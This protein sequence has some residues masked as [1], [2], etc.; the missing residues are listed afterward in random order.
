LS[1][2]EKERDEEVTDVEKGSLGDIQ[3]PRSEKV[4]ERRE[5]AARDL[6]YV[7]AIIFSVIVL[8]PFAYFIFKGQIPK[9]LLG[10]LQ[11]VL[12]PVSTLLGLAFGFY[13]SSKRLQ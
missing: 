2:D 5:T 1:T 6:A 4:E 3:E 10:F 9:D 13:F 8:F 7:V 12:T 11:M